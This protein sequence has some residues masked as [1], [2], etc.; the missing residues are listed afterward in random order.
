MS[1][2]AILKKIEIQ[3]TLVKKLTS[4]TYG[5]TIIETVP[6][7]SDVKSKSYLWSF[8]FY[9]MPFEHPAI[10]DLC[11]IYGC[12]KHISLNH[13]QDPNGIKGVQKRSFIKN[14]CRV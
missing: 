6:L 14:V 11:F 5:H 2:E 8:V 9:V 4:K 3:L 12:T 1:E 7:Y 10:C 13:L